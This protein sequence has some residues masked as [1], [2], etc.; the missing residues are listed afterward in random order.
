MFVVALVC[1]VRR[2]HLK[3]RRTRASNAERNNETRQLN[4]RA[5]E[6]AVTYRHQQ[7]SIPTVP[8][9]LPVS[10]LNTT[11]EFTIVPSAPAEEHGELKEVGLKTHPEFNVSR[12]MI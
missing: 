1:N 2:K 9:L 5:N 3:N 12:Q 11:D 8:L 7:N 6:N 4:T 10:N